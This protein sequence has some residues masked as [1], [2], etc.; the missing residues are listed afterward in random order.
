VC[1]CVTLYGHHIKLRS[2]SL[3]PEW[4]GGGNRIKKIFKKGSAA[5]LLI[6]KATQP[7]LFNEKIL[8]WIT[9]RCTVWPINSVHINSIVSLIK[10]WKF[11]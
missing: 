8:L 10:L 9:Q 5:K 4:H 2:K 11:I 1:L 6:K 3:E 7:M